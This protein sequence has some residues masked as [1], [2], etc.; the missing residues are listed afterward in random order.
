MPGTTNDPPS[1]RTDLK[2]WQQN[3]RK[4][5]GAWEHLLRNLNPEKFDIACIQEPYLNPVKLANASN[6]GRYWDVIYP[7][8]HHASPDR[9]Q[10]IILINKRLSKNKWHAININSPNVMAIELLGLFGKVRIY[11]VYNP[12]DHDSVL[13]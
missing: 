2:I 8:N 5:Q 4:S 6:L 13:H 12:C 1:N 10:T 3:L 7:L 11:N 9:T